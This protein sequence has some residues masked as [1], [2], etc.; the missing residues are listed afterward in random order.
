MLA[1]L[2]LP[3][4]QSPGGSNEAGLGDSQEGPGFC[5][6]EGG[7][8]P[9]DPETL[10]LQYFGPGT[11]PLE[12]GQNGPETMAGKGIA[13]N[14]LNNN[15][16]TVNGGDKPGLTGAGNA[17]QDVKSN[18]GALYAGG[19]TPE[20][21]FQE[22]Y[23]QTLLGNNDTP[24]EP[25]LEMGSGLG[26][27]IRLAGAKGS[28]KGPGQSFSGNPEMLA[29]VAVGE[30]LDLENAGVEKNNNKASLT[31]SHG[32]GV[33]GQNL[34]SSI[35]PE[36]DSFMPGTFN[37]SDNNSLEGHS[38]ANSKND[39]FILAGKGQEVSGEAGEVY[40]GTSLQTHFVS[41]D[42]SI[43][44]GP[45]EGSAANAAVSNEAKAGLTG[46]TGE[47]SQDARVALENMA[48]RVL[49][50]VRAAAQARGRQRTL[51]LTLEPAHLGKVLLK[52]SLADGEIKAHFFTTSVMAKESLEGLLPQVKEL[53][54]QNHYKLN[55]A[56]AFYTGDPGGGPGQGWGSD[57][58]FS[59]ERIKFALEDEVPDS[60]E[61][62]PVENQ[63][64]GGT[65]TDY[66]I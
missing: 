50:E 54:A 6:Q 25:P 60:G 41:T 43:S 20:L 12:A 58:N 46:G 59:H 64:S 23:L 49:M 31:N 22:P 57:G 39:G 32:L 7:N 63:T 13:N 35:T 29:T 34:K 5:P 61:E 8:Y 21:G 44:G 24:L 40:K 4:E 28:V 26:M 1:G 9:G 65:S 14:V 27:A 66:L 42:M 10:H 17:V 51:S 16:F 3:P 52:V 36:N 45:G 19:G 15:F 53:L 47:M 37:R 33:G 38:Q 18:T 62:A 11:S 56:A 55:E 48:Q 30:Q 2:M